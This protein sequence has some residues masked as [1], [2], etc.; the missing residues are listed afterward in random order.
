MTSFIPSKFSAGAM[1]L[2]GAC[3]LATG[4]VGLDVNATQKLI[5]GVIL[6]LLVQGFD[7][8]ALYR[9]NFLFGHPSFGSSAG[10]GNREFVEFFFCIFP[11]RGCSVIANRSARVLR[12][13]AIA[14][15]VAVLGKKL[16]QSCDGFGNCLPRRFAAE[17]LA[18]D[19]ALTVEV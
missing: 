8:L 2:P 6:A 4:V 11:S 7:V 16:L 12:V 9:L 14:I 13:N 5:G 15:D 3:Q 10:N 18:D 19:F 1:I 17:P